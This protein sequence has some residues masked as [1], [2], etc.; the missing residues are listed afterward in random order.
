MNYYYDPEVAAQV[1]A[2][3]NYICPVQGAQAEM[4][5]I[6][7]EL[8]KSPFIFPTASSWRRPRSSAALTPQE[9]AD[10]RRDLARR[11]WATDGTRRLGPAER[12]G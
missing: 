6:D 1:A 3:V 2:Y 10:V 7:P 8:A 11:C 4:E 9:E 12:D 5:K